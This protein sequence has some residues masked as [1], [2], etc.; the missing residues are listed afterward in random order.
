MKP[1]IAILLLLSLLLQACDSQPE[2]S[3]EEVAEKAAAEQQ[4]AADPTRGEKIAQACM[5]CH[6]ASGN[7]V[8]P[9]YPQIN[10]LQQNYLSKS[11]LDYL[12]GKRK[13]EAM[14]LS[15]IHI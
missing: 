13:H 12:S 8:K 6:P 5:E 2:P 14:N 15:L 7:I 3:P 4:A 11:L 10:G 9:Q 1:I